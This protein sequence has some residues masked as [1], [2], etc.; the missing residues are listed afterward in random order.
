MATL[1]R[2]G[3]LM[4]TD[5]NRLSNR[6]QFA[7]EAALQ[8]LAETFRGPIIRPPTPLGI[9]TSLALQ[10]NLLELWAV[11]SQAG[12]A[13]MAR[14]MGGF[15][16]DE[17]NYAQSHVSRLATDILALEYS[18]AFNRPLLYSELQQVNAGNI[19]HPRIPEPT[20][21]EHD[22]KN[23]KLL[24]DLKSTPELEAVGYKTPVVPNKFICAIS[25]Q[26]MDDPVSPRVSSDPLETGYMQCDMHTFEKDDI[27][28][29][30]KIKKTNPINRDPLTVDLLIENEDLRLEIE[31][32]LEEKRAEKMMACIFLKCLTLSPEERDE[33]NTAYYARHFALVPYAS[34]EVIPYTPPI[35]LLAKKEA[36]LYLFLVGFA[37]CT[38]AMSVVLKQQYD[39]P[40]SGRITELSEE[41]SAGFRANSIFPTIENQSNALAKGASQ[42]KL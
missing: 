26:I 9:A 36:I 23:T 18:T 32:W 11:N 20:A 37:A 29:W 31:S 41:E 34:R 6:Q 38:V 16:S 2:M 35:E 28:R 39:F 5:E 25:N 33:L 1:M 10:Q 24:E 12:A 13:R 4:N 30:L 3:G 40:E 17:V 19:S 27:E 7:A 21:R 15:A 14:M 22:Y 42:P 8:A